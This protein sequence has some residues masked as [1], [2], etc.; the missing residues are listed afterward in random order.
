MP[1]TSQRTRVPSLKALANKGLDFQIYEDPE[2]TN[3]PTTANPRPRDT[4]STSEVIEA[5]HTSQPI[6]SRGSKKKKKQTA[7]P[8]ITSNINEEAP[9]PKLY[10]ILSQTKSARQL[11]QDPVTAL[12]P[13]VAKE[14]ASW[15]DIPLEGAPGENPYT[16]GILPAAPLD[17]E[18]ES[19]E[20]YYAHPEFSPMPRRIHKG[21]VNL[22][23]DLTDP[24]DLFTLFYPREH[25]EI[26]VHSTNKYAEEKMELERRGDSE[27][28]FHSRYLNWKPLTIRETY[29]FLGILVLL[30]SDRRP[31]IE[32]YWRTPRA[33]GEAPSAFHN[34]MGLKRFET[35]H[36]LFTVSVTS[37]DEPCTDDPPRRA[38]TPKRKPIARSAPH[39]NDTSD[40]ESLPPGHWEKVEPLASHIRDTC[41][42][43]Y[44]PG[45]HL[46][47][48]EVMLAFRG[49]SKDTTKLKNK[50][51]G[52]G[53]KNWV[54]AEHGYVWKWEW[55]SVDKG[56]E[57]AREPLDSRIPKE[58][59]ETQ[60]MIMRL[61]LALPTDSLDF[62]LYLDNLFTSLPLAKALKKAS[63]GVTGTTRKN[64]R[65]TPQWL[66]TLKQKNKELVW[67][68]ALGE[69]I[70]GVLIFLWQDNNVVIGMLSILLLHDGL[71][72]ANGWPPTSDLYSALNPSTNGCC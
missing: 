12:F 13:L 7:G 24:I 10:S 35:I 19:M 8:L 34:Y 69:V 72:I 52:E 11:R 46:A 50:P 53:F 28:S 58:L 63:I 60:R 54:L 47:I 3:A 66:L 48:D 31:K 68:S 14:Y 32:D 33:A 44:T 36:R 42:R 29:I 2:S 37:V 65:G 30:G 23:E 40:R 71:R 39:I 16:E 5:I 1:R 38:L 49:R 43:V 59:P 21:Q 22:P 45:T 27:L 20:G 56:S 51:I 57:G 4:T 70:E 6:S 67:N 18:A 26:F 25:I 15:D 55:H 61:A 9:P 64:T 17:P 62:I 41:Q